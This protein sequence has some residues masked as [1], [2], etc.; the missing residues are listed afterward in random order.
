MRYVGFDNRKK[1]MVAPDYEQIGK[2]R[3]YFYKADSLE[4]AIQRFWTTR[5]DKDDS[6]GLRIRGDGEAARD[7]RARW[8]GRLDVPVLKPDELDGFLKGRRWDAIRG[9][10]PETDR[11]EQYGLFLRNLLDCDDWRRAR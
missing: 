10:D 4:Y 9:P 2:G 3:F 7:A 5:N 11:C 8:G 1:D 6:K